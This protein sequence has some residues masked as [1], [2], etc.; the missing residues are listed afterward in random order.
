MSCLRAKAWRKLRPQPFHCLC[1]KNSMPAEGLQHDT[2]TNRHLFPRQMIHN[3]IRQTRRSAMN[4][5]LVPSAV[6]DEGTFGDES[7]VRHRKILEMQSAFRSEE[8]TSE[9]QSPM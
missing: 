4:T 8:H 1:Q 6:R 3:V 9:L 7:E 2:F 5:K